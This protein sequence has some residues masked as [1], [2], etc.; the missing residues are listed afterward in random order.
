MKTEYIIIGGV[1]AGGV[2]GGV[3]GRL[4]GTLF[5]DADTGMWFGAL[6]GASFLAILLF[7]RQK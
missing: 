4:I 2:F 1:A 3:V 5:G 6:L 7:L